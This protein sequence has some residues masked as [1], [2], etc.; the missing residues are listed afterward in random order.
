LES[1]GVYGNPQ[2]IKH[3]HNISYG[4]L[5][6]GKEIINPPEKPEE[7][8]NE[9]GFEIGAETHQINQPRTCQPT[10]TP[11]VFP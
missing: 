2:L 4:L 7:A 8:A 10:D 3:F 6:K 9:V 1:S 5:V 11:A